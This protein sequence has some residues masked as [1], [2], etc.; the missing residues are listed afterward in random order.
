LVELFL[1]VGHENPDVIAARR[2]LS[3]LLF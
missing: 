1:I 3:F 2:E